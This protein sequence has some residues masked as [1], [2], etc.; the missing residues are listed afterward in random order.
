MVF[1]NNSG[2]LL[3]I[4]GPEKA[5]LCRDPSP[6]QSLALTANMEAGRILSHLW[7]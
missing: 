3:W 2:H 1:L 7:A 4:C 6:D 5:V